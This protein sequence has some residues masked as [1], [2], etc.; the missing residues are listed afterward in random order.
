MFLRTRP[1]ASFPLV[2]PR[3][4]RLFVPTFPLTKCFVVVEMSTVH[5]AHSECAQPWGEKT[6]VVCDAPY[7]VSWR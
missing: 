5:R 7:R 3:R 4:M 6:T 1:C 2:H